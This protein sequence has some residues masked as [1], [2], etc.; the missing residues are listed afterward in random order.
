[1]NR[2]ELILAL[3]DSLSRMKGFDCGYTTDN[4]NQMI[5]NYKEKRYVLSLKE[6]ENP[7]EDIFDDIDKYL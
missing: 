2:F 1:M 6:V 5:V 4:K 7:S 3:N